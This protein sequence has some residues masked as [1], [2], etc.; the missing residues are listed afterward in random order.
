MQFE[1]IR[2]YTDNE[3][4]GVVARLR[5][6][7]ELRDGF[8]A[9]LFP[10]FYRLSPG[11]AR[12]TTRGL[13]WL[14]ARKFRTI[15]DVQV[16][17]GRLIDHM[18]STTVASLSFNGLQHLEHNAPYIFISN[19]RDITL[20][21]ALLNRVLHGEG[22]PTCQIAVG[23]NL[24]GTPYADDLMRLNR[25]FIVQRSAV[26]LKAQYAA[27][28]RTSAYIRQ[29][30]ESGA[31]VWISQ[32][33][34]RAKDGF[35]RTEP[36]LLKM[37]ALAYRRETKNVGEV[38]RRVQIVPVSISYELD[39][40]DEQKAHELWSIEQHGSFEKSADAD[41][42]SIVAGVQGYKGRVHLEFAAPLDGDYQSAET[43][44]RAL[45]KAIVGGLRV[46]PTNIDADQ[47]LGAHERQSQLPRLAK[48]TDSFNARIAATRSAE[49]PFLLRQYANVL[50]NRVELGLE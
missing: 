9:F 31:S 25:G 7:F 50:R 30:I 37:L 46:F 33:E 6:S 41:R 22:F 29:S 11:L 5:A 1:S 2:P 40:C 12:S 17:T 39:P 14:R 38:C 48:V 42:A 47:L 27:L 24:F 28:E 45:D 19:H 26:G 44:A 18:L 36:A 21:S 8:A 23:D 13:L 10:R 20:D 49:R 32:R 4:P 34:G 16:M 3:V 35:D 43:I 15:H